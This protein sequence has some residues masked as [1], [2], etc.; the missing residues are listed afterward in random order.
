MGNLH[1]GHVR[2]VT[3]ARDAAQRVI[4]SIFVNPLQFGPNEDFAAYPRTPEEDRRLL[5]KARADLLFQPEVPDIYPAGHEHSTIVDVP[6]SRAFC[7]A[8]FGR[9][10]SQ[11]SRQSWRNFSTLCS[12]TWPCSARRTTSSC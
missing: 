1:D 10:I 4:V 2:L 12:R 8:L 5:E 7:V 3:Q 11:A 9:V 6:D